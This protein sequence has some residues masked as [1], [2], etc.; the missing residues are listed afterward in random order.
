MSCLGFF[1]FASS[2]LWINS[3][4]HKDIKFTTVCNASKSSNAT[5]SPGCI[6]GGAGISAPP[7]QAASCQSQ[8]RMH[9]AGDPERSLRNGDKCLAQGPAALFRKA[10]LT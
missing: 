6:I 1:S 4:V 3:L 9:S 10:A 2:L 5:K 7:E 8:T